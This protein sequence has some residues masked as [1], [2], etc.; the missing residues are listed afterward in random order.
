MFISTVRSGFV[1]YQPVVKL[2]IVFALAS[3]LPSNVMQF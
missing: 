3:V 1:L 2:N